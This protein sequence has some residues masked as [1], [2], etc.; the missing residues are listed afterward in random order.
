[1]TPDHPTRRAIPAAAL[2]AILACA[3]VVGPSTAV[4]QELAPPRFD[5]ATIPLAVSALSPPRPPAGDT[6]VRRAP[7]PR[8]AL[9]TALGGVVLGGGMVLLGLWSD[10]VAKDTDEFISDGEAL[11]LLG[12]AFGYPFGSAIG[13]R[14]AAK[15]DGQRPRLSR[16]VLVSLLGVGAGGLVWNQFGEQFESR[17]VDSNSWE[18][19]AALGLLTH[20]AFTSVGTWMLPVE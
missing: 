13:A 8:V 20:W 15:V 3:Q 2:P 1:M 18:V 12:I 14:W 4:A 6:A 11:A 17:G 10:A 16:V 19:G 7:L 9:G 5:R